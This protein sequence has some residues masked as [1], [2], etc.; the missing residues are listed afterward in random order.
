MSIGY[1]YL[2]RTPSLRRYVS[3]CTSSF[4]W[5]DKVRCCPRCLAWGVIPAAQKFPPGFN[6]DSLLAESTSRTTPCSPKVF[7]IPR[8]ANLGRAVATA[9]VATLLLSGQRVTTVRPGRRRRRGRE[10]GLVP[11]PLSSPCWVPSLQ[12]GENARDPQ[13]VGKPCGISLWYQAFKAGKHKRQKQKTLG[14]N[15]C[16]CQGN[17]TESWASVKQFYNLHLV[18]K[19]ELLRSYS[20]THSGL[21]Q[22]RESFLSDSCSSFPPV[23]GS[24]RPSIRA[25]ST[26]HPLGSGGLFLRPVVL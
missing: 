22:S 19:A 18:V 14:Y 11:G 12:V 20:F 26:H 17:A 9:L 8:M 25:L 4:T 10:G 5:K 21:P 13:S 3:T 15:L 1:Q 7:S 16:F 24:V 6:G 2:T 23:P